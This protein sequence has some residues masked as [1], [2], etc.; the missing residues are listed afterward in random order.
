MPGFPNSPTRF[1][2]IAC[3]LRRALLLRLPLV[4]DRGRGTL[5]ILCDLPVGGQGAKRI[6]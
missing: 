4:I 1:G 6:G 2:R 5:A 3:R